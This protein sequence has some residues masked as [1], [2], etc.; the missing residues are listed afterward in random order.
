MTS[1]PR[2]KSDILL[3]S[4]CEET[5][6][7]LLRFFYPDADEIFDF[8]QPFEVMDKELREIFPE[9]Q[10]KGGTRHADLLVKV[11]LRKGGVEFILI[12]LEIESGNRKNFSR[13]MF[14]YGFRLFDRFNA[15]VAAIAVYTGDE[16]QRRPDRY[17]RKVLDTEIIYKYRTYHIFDHSDQELLAMK[18]PFA[19]VVLTARKALLEGKIPQVQLN[20]ERTLIARAMITCGRYSHEQIERF[21]WFLTNMIFI[22]DPEINRN[23]DTII[24]SL[25]GRTSIMGIIETVKEITRNEGIQLGIEQ[26]IEKGLEKG[27]EKGIQQGAEKK[28]LI[29]VQNLISMFNF[30][31]K[32]AAEAANVPLSFVKKVRASLEAGRN[33]S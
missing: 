21:I 5:F 33:K 24:D 6:P 25:T 14:E 13:R 18:N 3:K 23:F 32:Q 22:E 9:R 11:F 26:G 31:D 7:D 19:L 15:P 20:E 29:V 27:L 12:H 4:A 8:G 28:S 10:K 30:S 2:K 17:H 1:L 16:Q